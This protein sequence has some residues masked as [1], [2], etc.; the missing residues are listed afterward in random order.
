MVFSAD[1]FASSLFR[2]PHRLRVVVG[3]NTCELGRGKHLAPGRRTLAVTAEAECPVPFY[4][5]IQIKTVAIKWTVF[6]FLNKSIRSPR[7]RARS[8]TKQ[9]L[10]IRL[11]SLRSAQAA[12]II[13]RRE[14]REHLVRATRRPNLQKVAWIR[15]ESSVAALLNEEEPSW[16]IHRQPSLLP[17]A[18]GKLLSG[19]NSSLQMRNKRNINDNPRSSSQQ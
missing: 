13:I 19:S 10:L 12:W 8:N 6:F 11:I 16:P 14:D 3:G 18:S 2:S 9:F 7:R 15:K 5:K 1:F 17:A 4:W